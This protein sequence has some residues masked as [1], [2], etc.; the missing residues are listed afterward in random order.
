MDPLEIEGHFWLPQ[1]PDNKVAGRLLFDDNDRGT[2][3]LYGS[4]EVDLGQTT[5]IV[6]ATDDG[7]YTLEGCFL[8]KRSRGR[9]TREA[10]R[11]GRIFGGVEYG[12]DDEPMFD[13][14][15]L[16]L[17]NLNEWTSPGHIEG[18]LLPFDSEDVHPYILTL[19]YI[20]PQTIRTASGALSLAQWRGF[21]GDGLNERS[22][23]QS[24]LFHFEADRSMSV[25][26]IVDVASDLQDL[27]SIGTKATAA[28][29]YLHLYT[30]G[31][32]DSFGNKK[33]IRLLAP[34][35]AKR[36]KVGLHPYDMAFTFDELGGM[37][38][39]RRWLDAAE[40]HRP[41]L[42]MVMNTRY[43][44]M[45]TGDRFLHRV[46]A[47]ERMYEQWSGNNTTV[48]VD[49]LKQLCEFA[50]SPVQGLVPDVEV[51]CEK[52]KSE[53][54]NVA[55]HLGR[56]IH[57]DPGELF[58]SSEVAYWLFVVCLLRLSGAPDAV[59]DHISRNPSVQFLAEAMGVKTLS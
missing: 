11:V 10:F 36:D 30:D 43:V 27:V 45:F 12:Q 42:G 7:A 2:L 13:E 46:A 50:G 22:L 18:D 26:D 56:I 25:A 4:L 49:R 55:H 34:W 23:T 1:M 6:A 58:Y 57:Q 32:R 40:A 59:F 44:R 5:R 3:S 48:L 9:I 33:G 14:F 20:D 29:E 28:F 21:E 31:H 15:R 16:S 37:E 51:W 52:A 39:V 53:R 54:H 8:K 35:H 24:M 17:T 19:K 41:G 47:L 38:G